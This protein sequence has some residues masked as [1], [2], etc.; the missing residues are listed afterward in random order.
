MDIGGF[1]LF[2]GSRVGTLLAS[3]GLEDPTYRYRLA[4]LKLR[5]VSCRAWAGLENG[6]PLQASG[7][8]QPSQKESL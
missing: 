7:L 2:G 8:R 1:G 3:R 6:C 5:L 4:W